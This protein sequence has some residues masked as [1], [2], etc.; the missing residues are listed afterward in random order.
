M[1]S[2][3]ETTVST[4]PRTLALNEIGV[5]SATGGVVPTVFGNAAITMGNAALLNYGVV[6][7]DHTNAIVLSAAGAQIENHG[8]ISGGGNLAVI[9]GFFGSASTSL[10]LV[11]FGTIA[12]Q[13]NTDTSGILTFGGGNRITNFG[14]ISALL[15]TAIELFDE[16]DLAVG[17]GSTIDN[18]GRIVGGFS[19]AIEI[20]NNDDDVLH[21]SGAIIGS[22]GMGGGANRIT[23]SGTIDGAIS[24]GAGGDFV[25][26]SGTINGNIQTGEGNFFLL[27]PGTIVGDIVLGF[28]GSDTID[29]RYGH[30]IGSVRDF[31]GDDIYIV[32]D[33]KVSIIDNG[34]NFDEVQSYVDFAMPT[35]IESLRLMGTAVVG[36]G[37]SG[38]NTIFGST[39]D[40]LV[41]G[42][43]GLDTIVGDLGADTVR[44]GAEDDLV[45]GGDDDDV[46]SG[47]DGNDLL[48]GDAG[49]DRLTGGLDNDSLIG[50]TGDDSL[51][52]GF[53]NDALQ[54]G[55]GDDV[56]QGGRGRDTLNGGFDRDV[57]VY[58]KAT[59]S[60]VAV[61]GRDI[62]SA[63]QN[64]TDQIDLSKMD[65]K[66]TTAADDVFTFI[67]T[68]AFSGAAGQLHYVVSGANIVVEGDQNGDGTADF[69]IQL[70]AIAS[71]DAFDFVL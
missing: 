41:N 69:A 18:A 40:I 52:G 22:V 21:N 64:G 54:G 20:N 60:T 50:L 49:D 32:D 43:S 13:G 1:T 7:G 44:G 70:N 51:F 47:G 68:A 29:L 55:D 8:S 23:N 4:T 30:L 33:S 26:N 31:G 24:F 28:T 35:G 45:S 6:A 2:F 62:I 56:L 61:A 71:V 57:F 3:V 58:L 65:A 27:N 34:G 63:F 67:G 17:T 10:D 59:D 38:D 66:T 48:N 12:A 19:F 16:N 9:N 53:G 15:D 14:E 11:N 36:I 46:V 37:N 25:D 39:V 42:G 5:I